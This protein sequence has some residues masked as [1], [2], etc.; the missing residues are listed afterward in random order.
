MTGTPC[1]RAR[2]LAKEEEFNKEHK[3]SDTFKDL[4]KDFLMLWTVNLESLEENKK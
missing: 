3:T 1:T 4:F 2:I